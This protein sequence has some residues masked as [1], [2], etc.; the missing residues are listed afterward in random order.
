MIVKMYR[1]FMSGVVLDW[2]ANLSLDDVNQAF[3]M[4]DDFVLK[5]KDTE[6]KLV[7]QFVVAGSPDDY[8][9]S[10][11]RVSNQDVELSCTMGFTT[12][13]VG[14]INTLTDRIT[15][16]YDVRFNDKSIIT[17]DNEQMQVI[18]V[19]HDY[20]QNKTYLKVQR[21]GNRS[22]HYMNTVIR[23]IH[24][25]PSMS[26]HNR[27][28]GMIRVDWSATDTDVPGNYELEISITRGSGENYFKWSVI[29]IHIRIDPDYNLA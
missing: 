7:L 1:C 24:G 27:S 20:S 3:N 12:S 21:L 6:P 9:V 10:L 2:F 17:I 26:I 13:L 8:P 15:S 16:T 5:Y 22:V 11:E 29:P 18:A 23:V 28:L 4:I 14:N 25:F 19:S